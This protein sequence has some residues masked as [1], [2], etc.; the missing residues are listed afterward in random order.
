MEPLTFLGPGASIASWPYLYLAQPPLYLLFYMHI[1]SNMPYGY[2]RIKP[3]CCQ[4]A[5]QRR[6]R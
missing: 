5:R 3:V 6:K 2:A 4:P 1:R